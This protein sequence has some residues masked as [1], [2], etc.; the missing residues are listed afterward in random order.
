MNYRSF[1]I[2]VYLAI[3]SCSSN[4]T[5]PAAIGPLPTEAQMRWHEME[6]NAF[7]HFTMNTFTDKEWGYGDENP[8][9]FDPTSAN[10]EQWITTLRDAG[11]KGVILTTKHHDGFCLWPSKYT[12]HSIARSPY[13]NGKG[14]IVREVSEA[15]KKYNLKFGI[16]MSPWD[17][18]RKDY[19]EPSYVEYYRNQLHEL[20]TQYGPVFEMWLMVQTEVMDF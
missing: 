7:I 1:L 14:D 12:D 2:L 11:F 16:Y 10:V 19:G 18:N 9:M 15:C 20:F 3:V 8:A 13:Q 4:T 17:R 6:T 5:R